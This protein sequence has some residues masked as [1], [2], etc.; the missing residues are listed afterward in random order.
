MYASDIENLF[1][2]AQPGRPMLLANNKK[3]LLSDAMTLTGGAIGAVAC[4]KFGM[5]IVGTSLL[6]LLGDCFL[7]LLIY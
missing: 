5:L 6:S 1:L 3:Q 2:T 4:R 7:C